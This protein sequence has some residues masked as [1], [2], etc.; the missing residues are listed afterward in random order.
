MNG[1][2]LTTQ[3]ALQ[4]LFT[5]DPEL[6]SIVLL[7][8]SVSLKAILLTTPFA[9]LVSFALSHGKFPGIRIILAKKH[10]ATIGCPITTG[11]FAWIAAH[12]AEE[13]RLDGKHNITPYWRTL[14]TGGVINP[15]YPGG[16]EGQKKILESFES[17]RLTFST[18]N[19]RV[20]PFQ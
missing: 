15:K 11:I 5:G 3:Q 17:S 13:A 10:N 19:H 12:A 6:W 18:L 9:F 16:V 1:L 14:K 7:S 20:Y 4:L 8:F 2:L